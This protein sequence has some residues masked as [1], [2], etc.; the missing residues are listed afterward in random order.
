MS[1]PSLG[2]REVA[3]WLES[4]TRRIASNNDFGA[5]RLSTRTDTNR[6]DIAPSLAANLRQDTNQK[7][8]MHEV[9]RMPV[10]TCFW[11]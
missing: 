1:T 2:R 5:S 6:H 11:T 9:P 7:E 4:E 8:R 10:Y 3:D